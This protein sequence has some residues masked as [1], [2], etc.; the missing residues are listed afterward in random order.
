M[1]EAVEVTKSKLKLDLKTKIYITKDYDMF[2][3]KP[4]NRDINQALV[5]KLYTSIYMNGYYDVSILIVGDNMTVLDGQ[6]RIAALQRIKQ[7]TGASYD[8]RFIVNREF[9]DLTKIISWQKDRA[10]WT[11]MDYAVSYTEMGNAHY[12]TYLDFRAK[13]KLTHTAAV[14]LLMGRTT[15]GGSNAEKFKRGEFQ[16]EDLSRSQE[17]VKRLEALSIFYDFT[18]TRNFI[19]A[20]ILHWRHPE[21]SNDEF[22]NKVEKF[23]GLLYN[24]INITE[25]VRIIG[26]LYNYH[27]KKR[28][29]FNLKP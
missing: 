27:N 2:R 26:D 15:T 13:H 1:K 7:D 14:L 10:S 12:K 21:F 4:G 19:R 20:L 5:N 22:M 25:F 29:E 16:V 18:F 24:C 28:I 17:Y 8:V 6:H 9:D 23:R 3:K 11:T